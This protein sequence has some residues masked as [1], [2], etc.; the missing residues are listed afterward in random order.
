MVTLSHYIWLVAGL[1]MG[2]EAAYFMSTRKQKEKDE[3]ACVP[4]L[5]QGHTSIELTSLR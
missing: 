2:E 5:L 4:L 1:S 3:E